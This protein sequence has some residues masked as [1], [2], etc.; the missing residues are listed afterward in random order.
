MRARLLGLG[1]AALLVALGVAP[2]ARAEFG[3]LR[4]ISKTPAEQAGVAAAPA[5]S[6]DG[7]FVA[8]QGSLGGR[9]GVFREE[10]ATGA[11]VPVT[12]GSAFVEDAP[13]AD[14]AAPSISADGRYVSF[15]TTA[16][17]DPVDD[18]AEGTKD[19]YV[20][21][22]ATSPPIY[23]L[24]SALDRPGTS[25]PAGVGHAEPGQPLGL[26][27]SGAGGS[28][29]TG[30]V[31]LSG[32]GRTVAFVVVAPSDLTA[33]PGGSTEGTPTP[34]GQIVVRNLDTGCTS[35][36]SAA[37][38]PDGA[39]T[40]EP[41]P[42]GA[43][44]Q[45]PALPLLVG[46]AISADGT[47]VAW[48][49]AHLSAQAPMAAPERERIEALDTNGTMPYDEPLWRRIADGPGAPIRRIVGGEAP[50]SDLFD[51]NQNLN[52]AEGWLGV[53]RVDGVPQLSA[54]GQTV[55]LVGNPT[56]S[57]NVFLVDMAPG[58]A[59]AAAIT[60][61]TREVTVNPSDPG[62]GVNREP[63]VPLNGHIFDLAV[64][65]DGR[66]IAFATARQRFPL[67]P[68]NLI[69]TGPAQVGLAELYVIDLEA[70]TLERVTHGIGGEDEA[71]L[72]AAQT[73]EE[74]AGATSPSF[75][76]GGSLV[77]FAST[78]GNLVEGDGNEASDVFL[79]EIREA[80]RGVGASAIGAAPG[81]GTG[82][83]G[84]L[85]LTAISMPDGSVRLLAAVP[86]AG[87]LRAK[88]T[89]A[90][91]PGARARRLARRRAQA[92]A[93]GIVRMTLRLPR[94]LRPRA[95]GA[96]GLW[97]KAAVTFRA[98]GR[99]KPLR[100]KVQVHFHVHRAKHQ[101]GKK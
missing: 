47:T 86:A 69:G 77:A 88:A 70:E 60:Q 6:A 7:R 75:A 99:A 40:D 39:M 9:T 37:I 64:S 48:L 31:A 1:A 36:V 66:R 45:K 43:V 71:S 81:R 56:E 32:D 27:Y 54:D 72:G 20:A 58:L 89:G 87:R 29:A 91:K 3:P 101:K 73:A 18:T 84:R 17:L 23:E 5:I 34:G 80:P 96:E 22:L 57:T 19:V 4:L 52:A 13:G 90:P 38:G 74:G 76:A 16:R 49:G 63:F 2:A 83:R 8:F 62:E 59:R 67:A 15:T 55:A 97:A 95:H 65:A 53:A 21:D 50:F 25:C 44:I 94:R 24:A 100:G 79:D 11:I 92:P 33:A 14:A 98:P 78:A 41:V 42:G 85:R 26:T 51:K 30:R 12:T 28:Q 46:A 68:P 10:L 35:L 93:A 82:G 61:L